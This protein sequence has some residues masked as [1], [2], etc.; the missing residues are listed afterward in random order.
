M[1]LFCILRY[2]WG[3]PFVNVGRST[4]A[5]LMDHIPRCP[6]LLC[7]IQLHDRVVLVLEEFTLESGATKGRDLREEVRRFWSGASRDRHG[8]V[9]WL[10]F[11]APHT[12]SSCC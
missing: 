5:M 9:V 2:K 10:E 7:V 6:C 3:A 11:R 8:D 1:V 12:P 4:F